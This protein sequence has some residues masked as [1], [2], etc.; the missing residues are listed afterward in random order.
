M[1]WYA[2]FQGYGYLLSVVQHPYGESD[3]A[4]QQSDREQRA[5]LGYVGPFPPLD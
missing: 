5:Y 4:R 3:Q 2:D 1:D